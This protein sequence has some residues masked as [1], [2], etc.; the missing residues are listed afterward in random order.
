MY[1]TKCLDLCTFSIR[2]SK[3]QLKLHRKFAGNRYKDVKFSSVSF[4]RQWL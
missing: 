3:F 4:V 1:L 2:L